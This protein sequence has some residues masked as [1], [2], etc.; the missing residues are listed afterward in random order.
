MPARTGSVKLPVEQVRQPSERLPKASL[1]SRERPAN[2]LPGQAL[3]Y[4]R[5]GADIDGIVIIDELIANGGRIDPNHEHQQQRRDGERVGRPQAWGPRPALVASHTFM[6][7]GTEGLG[8]RPRREGVQMRASLC[9]VGV[10]PKRLAILRGGFLALSSALEDE[11]EFKMEP[12]IVR[13][14]VQSGAEL[15][16]GLVEAPKFGG[17]VAEGNAGGQVVG[18]KAQ[19]GAEFGRGLSKS[20]LADEDAAEVAVGAA[21]GGVGIQDFTE[22]GAG[23][24]KLAKPRQTNAEVVLRLQVAGRLLQRKAVLNHGFSK[25]AALG[26]GGGEVFARSRL[27][28]PQFKRSLVKGDCVAELPLAGE[29][30]GKVVKRFEA[31]VER[32][33]GAI[34]LN[35]LLSAAVL[36][37]LL[38]IIAP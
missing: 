36:R 8:L 10:L 31:L 14:L 27:P 35:S 21:V 28:R 29:G 38:S 37:R 2:A 18:R 19:D 22:Q 33:R 15:L 34:M 3:L 9:M 5:G 23:F 12:G 11:A 25:P 1:R 6:G 13:R 26:Q 17:R 7:A 20:F 4:V 16:D 32:E 24:V 30:E